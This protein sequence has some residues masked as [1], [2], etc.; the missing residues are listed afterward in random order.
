[1]SYL[2]KVLSHALSC[3]EPQKDRKEV[4]K[5]DIFPFKKNETSRLSELIDLAKFTQEL[6]E[7]SKSKLS[8]FTFIGCSPLPFNEFCLRECGRT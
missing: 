4:N 8:T 1:M 6:K 3:V 5:V 2:S 7:E